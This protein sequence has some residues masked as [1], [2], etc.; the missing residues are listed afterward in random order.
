MMMNMKNMI[1]KSLLPGDPDLGILFVRVSIGVLMLTH[2]LPKMAQLFS[3][4]PVAFVGVFGMSVTL[5]LALAVF[6]EVL[7]SL[8]IFAG[9]GTRFA[10]VPLIVTMATAA[11]LI[12]AADQFAKKEMAL[13]YLAG[14]IFLFIVG[15]GKYSL[16]HLLSNKSL[17]I[18]RRS[19]L[20]EQ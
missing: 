2:G 14:Y 12:H 9:L 20:A 5:S 10:A 15:S 13:I 7:C 6:A 17:P 3:D 1:E 16:D 4:Q 11:F 8:L 18:G 19:T